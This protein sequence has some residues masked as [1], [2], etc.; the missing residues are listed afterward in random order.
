MVNKIISE[1]S[2]KYILKFSSA[3]SDVKDFSFSTNE[4]SVAL[5]ENNSIEIFSFGSENAYWR[6]RLPDNDKIERLEWYR[7]TAHLFA[8]YPEEIRFLDLND[9]ALENFPAVASGNSARYDEPSNKLYFV[10]KNGLWS[11]TFPK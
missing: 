7:D 2:S 8:V 3:A 1:P 4:N 9:K 10:K 5:L 6:F 11:L